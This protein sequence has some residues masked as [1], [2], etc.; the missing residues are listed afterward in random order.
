MQHSLTYQKWLES[1]FRLI[2]GGEEDPT[3]PAAGGGDPDPAD[4]DPAPAPGDD[5]AAGGDTD[6]DPDPNDDPDPDPDEVE[7]DRI[8]NERDDARKKL[9]N[10]E[11]AAQKAK[12]EARKAREEA[13]K[14]HGNWEQVAKEREA[15][16]ADA[17]ERAQSS[18]QRAIT[19]EENLDKFQR[20]VRITRLAAKLCFKDPGDA[21]LQLQGKPE[22]TGD[23][24]SCERALRE[25][26]KQKPYFIDERR[27]RGRAMNGGG[28]GGPTLTADQLKTMTPEQINDAWE[29]G[30]VQQALSGGG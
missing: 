6:P 14:K 1:Q 28:G 4:P 24:K 5:P 17:N 15:E 11:A 7:L 19:A 29:K 30:L 23:D 16:L 13:A 12:Q 18:E 10:A 25:L 26:A 3:D 21:I 27:A 2:A 22:A 9:A 20:E 8:R